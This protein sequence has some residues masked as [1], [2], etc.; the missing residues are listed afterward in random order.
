MA[1]DKRT[2]RQTI[3]DLDSFVNNHIMSKL[4]WHEKLIYGIYGLLVMILAAII[5]QGVVG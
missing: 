3:K 5:T 2:T 1:E 4:G